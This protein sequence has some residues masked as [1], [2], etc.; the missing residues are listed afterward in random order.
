MHFLSLFRHTMW[1]LIE[2]ALQKS[3][4]VLGLA[5]VVQFLIR[6]HGSRSPCREVSSE[7]SAVCCVPTDTLD[8]K[9]LTQRMFQVFS[10]TALWFLSIHVEGWGRVS[11]GT[12]ATRGPWMM[13]KY[14]AFCRIRIG[15][16]SR[17]TRR[18]PTP[19]LLYLPQ[20]QHD[21]A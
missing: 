5:P 18:K 7:T 11:F 13:D 6:S 19:L 17:S 3:W 15:R 16:G 8:G 14:G 10:Q 2:S 9:H 1:L 12:P 20:I 4:D 21:T